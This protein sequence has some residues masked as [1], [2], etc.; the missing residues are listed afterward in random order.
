MEKC[1]CFHTFW[2]AACL[3]VDLMPDLPLDGQDM[4][5]FCPSLP[6]SPFFQSEV[7]FYLLD[8]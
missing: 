8:R 5:D 1:L 4:K 2:H 6:W 7:Y 3:P